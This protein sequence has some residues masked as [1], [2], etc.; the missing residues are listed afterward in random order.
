MRSSLL[1]RHWRRG[2]AHVDP[3]GTGAFACFSRHAPAAAG[4]AG[5]VHLR[6]PP[7]PWGC[8]EPLTSASSLWTS[9]KRASIASGAGPGA[10]TNSNLTRE[11]FARQ[12]VSVVGFDV[13]FASAT[14]APGWHPCALGEGLGQN[15]RLC[16]TTGSLGSFPRPMPCSLAAFMGMRRCW[17]TTSPVIGRGTPRCAPS[18]GGDWRPVARQA[19]GGH[20][21]EWLGANLSE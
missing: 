10:E 15:S 21:L 8:R 6:R 13:V 2:A 20:H 1:F 9:M 14:T 4:A 3:A 7:A 19:A 5:P 11:L 12:R 17:A 18:A 16:R